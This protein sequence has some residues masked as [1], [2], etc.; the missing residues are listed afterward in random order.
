M[1]SMQKVVIY[2]L[3]FMLKNIIY[4]LFSKG[5]KIQ[6]MDLCA[7]S[8]NILSSGKIDPSDDIMAIWIPLTIEIQ[9]QCKNSNAK[10]L[11]FLMNKF[12]YIL[13]IDQSY[14][15]SPK[16]KIINEGTLLY[17]GKKNMNYVLTDQYINHF[18]EFL[19]SKGFKVS[20]KEQINTD[21]FHDFEGKYNSDQYLTIEW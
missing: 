11:K 9:N 1:K 19:E 20:Y 16:T 3:H 13:K 12:K 17:R 14:I 18:K 15:H 10:S 21:D 5:S 4:R 2:F 7:K 6:Y 8:A